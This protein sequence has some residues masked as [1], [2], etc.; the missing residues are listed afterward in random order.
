MCGRPGEEYAADVVLAARR[1]LDEWEW[2][3]FQLHM[4]EGRE[5]SECC[6]KLGVDRG[7]F[8][9][10]V[11]RI[12]QRLGRVFRETKPYSLIPSEYFAGGRTINLN[13][14]YRCRVR[15]AATD[16]RRLGA[17]WMPLGGQ[18]REP[19][20]KHERHPWR[21]LTYAA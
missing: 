9:H 1:N 3:L 21:I 4:M 7:N 2:K 6:P 8:F 19:W 11:Y 17:K 20:T 15:T 5:W 13:A 10:A 18:E 16:T 12:E 14:M